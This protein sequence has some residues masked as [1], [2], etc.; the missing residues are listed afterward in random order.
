MFSCDAESNTRPE[1]CRGSTM[2]HRESERQRERGTE[3]KRER[4]SCPMTSRLPRDIHSTL[5]ITKGINYIK[6]IT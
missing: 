6:A 1:V 3:K 5:S 2:V 4:N